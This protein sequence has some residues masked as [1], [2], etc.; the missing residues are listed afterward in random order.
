MIQ[1]ESEKVEQISIQLEAENA[2]ISEQNAKMSSDSISEDDENNSIALMGEANTRAQQLQSSL[3][4]SRAKISKLTVSSNKRVRTLSRR[5]KTHKATSLKQQKQM[6]QEILIK[7]QEENE[8]EQVKNKLFL[9]RKQNIFVILL[10]FLA[11]FISF[12]IFSVISFDSFS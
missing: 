8:E 7:K 10:I 9:T 5:A 3:G 11:L 4:K 12:S 6:K 2:K 1:K